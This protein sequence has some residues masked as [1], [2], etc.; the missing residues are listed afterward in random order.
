MDRESG[1]VQITLELKAGFLNKFF[2]F[3]VVR[4]RWKLVGCVQGT[5]PPQIDVEEGVRAGKKTGGFRWR[6]FAQLNNE[7]NR[8]CREQ[9]NDNQGKGTLDAH[10]MEIRLVIIAPA[11]GAAE[12]WLAR[13][14]K[15]AGN[16]I[17]RQWPLWYLK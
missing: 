17:A 9:D 6:S 14:A 13:G 7:N 10:E 4:D 1:F 16:L 3:G 2:V 5:H 12:G 15:K 11:D 8:R